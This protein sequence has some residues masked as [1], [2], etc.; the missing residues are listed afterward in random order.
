M[1]SEVSSRRVRRGV[2]VVMVGWGEGM[3]CGPAGEEVEE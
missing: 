3:D 1:R 2:V